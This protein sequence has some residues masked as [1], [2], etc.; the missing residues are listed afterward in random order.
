MSVDDKRK[1]LFNKFTESFSFEPNKKIDNQVGQL[2]NDLTET[3]NEQLQEFLDSE[4]VT[5]MDLSDFSDDIHDWI[6]DH[7][8]ISIP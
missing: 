8:E 4:G 6:T 1:L 2:I 7:I 5:G 3:M